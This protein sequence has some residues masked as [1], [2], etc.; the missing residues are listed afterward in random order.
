M[1]ARQ[2][3]KEC[4]R[5]STQLCNSTTEDTITVTW[6]AYGPDDAAC[7][8]TQEFTGNLTLD[9][10]TPHLETTGHQRVG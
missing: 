5:F 7:C 10:D 8:A 1:L 9:G 2:R 3:R 4:S 6:R